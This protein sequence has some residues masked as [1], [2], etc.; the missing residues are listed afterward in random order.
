MNGLGYAIE[1]GVLTIEE[2]A[3]LLEELR[4]RLGD[5]RRGGVRHLMSNAAVRR[6]ASDDRLLSFAERFL[7]RPVIPYK[8]TLFNK[9]G[10]ANWLVSWHQ[11]TSLPLIKFDA[12]PEWGP[13]STKAGIDFAHAPAWALSRIVAL[14]IQLDS[15]E[16]T[17]G[18]LRLIEGSHKYGVL[19]S[20]DLSEAVRQGHEVLGLTGAGGVIAMSPLIVHASSKA[21]SSRPRRVLHIEYADSLE[22][23]PDIRLSI[24]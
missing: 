13:W 10:R 6:V 21:I 4:P 11:D 20:D 15:S 8:A 16:F 24:A 12:S 19:S 14:R 17:N 7:E 22:L 23:A 2:C 18:P 1:D 3:E 5:K 9:T